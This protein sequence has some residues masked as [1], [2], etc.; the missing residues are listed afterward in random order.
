[1]P[2]KITD[3]SIIK[4]VRDEIKKVG[5]STKLNYEELQKSYDELKKLMSE[6]EGKSDTL[7]TEKLKKYTDEITARQEMLDKKFAED[8]V[9]IDSQ[10]EEDKKSL[11]ERLD[12][13][14]VT[15]KRTPKSQVSPEN[16]ELVKKAAKRICN[17]YNDCQR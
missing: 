8:K 14:E 17:T 12:G 2:D 10:I 16:E 11:S 4:E 13:L 15:L 7:L 3:D 6:N 1:M 9:K 5:D